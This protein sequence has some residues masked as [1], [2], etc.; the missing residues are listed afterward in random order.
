MEIITRMFL[1][2]AAKSQ[3][4]PDPKLI[5]VIEIELSNMS[6][7]LTR[8]EPDSEKEMFSVEKL[9]QAGNRKSIIV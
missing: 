3:N 2:F 4:L 1:L 6:S 5:P 8:A 7:A 9:S